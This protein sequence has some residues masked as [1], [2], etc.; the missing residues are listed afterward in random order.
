MAEAQNDLYN[1]DKDAYKANLDEM[2]AAWQDF[3][4]QYK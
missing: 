4:E 1:F 2:L 3:Q